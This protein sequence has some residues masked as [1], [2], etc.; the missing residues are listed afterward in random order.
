AENL[1]QL[2]A[3][4]HGLVIVARVAVSSSIEINTLEDYER[5]QAW[6]REHEG[7]QS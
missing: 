5:A 6:V 1:E 3:L 7:G 4:E 2:R